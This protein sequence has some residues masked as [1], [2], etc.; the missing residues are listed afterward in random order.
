[1]DPA[2]ETAFPDSIVMPPSDAPADTP[3]FTVTEPE[4]FNAEPE[5]NSTFPERSSPE[6]DKEIEPEAELTLAVWPLSREI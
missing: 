5:P 4:F 2:V 1:M 6:L 3:L